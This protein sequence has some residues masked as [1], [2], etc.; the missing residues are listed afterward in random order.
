MPRRYWLGRCAPQAAARNRNPLRF[1]IAVARKRLRALQRLAPPSVHDQRSSGANVRNRR[2]RHS[3][4]KTVFP[5]VSTGRRDASHEVPDSPS[6]HRRPRCAVRD[7]RSPDD[8]ASVF[9]HPCGFPPCADLRHVPPPRGGRAFPGLLVATCF[10][11]RSPQVVGRQVK[12]VR[13]T[14]PAAGTLA[15]PCPNCD[16][17]QSFGRRSWGSCLSQL[18]SC[19]RVSAGVFHHA[20]PTCRSE[21]VRLDDF[22]RGTGRRIRSDALRPDAGHLPRLLG[23]SS[24]AIRA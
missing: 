11:A 15:R 21:D 19:P 12:R 4:H 1:V 16:A 5:T 13:R 24:R 8:P 23:F 9:T 2:P 18:C 10:S 20:H 22:G 6:A 7:C 3:S 14:K 17:F